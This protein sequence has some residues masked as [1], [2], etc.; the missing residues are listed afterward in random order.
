MEIKEFIEN[1]A[2][3]F[4]ETDSSEFTGD[5]EYKGLEEW[6]S[7]MSMAIIAMVAKEYKVNIK[8][9]DIKS[10]NTINDLFVLVESKA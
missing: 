9:Q 8:G 6:S 5:T 3:Q 2:N 10:C 1:F 7:L 4:E